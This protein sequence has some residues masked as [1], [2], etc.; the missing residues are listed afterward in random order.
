MTEC[1]LAGWRIPCGGNLD[2]HHVIPREWTR[3]NPAARRASEEPELIARVCSA[4]NAWTKLADVPEAR[5]LLLQHQARLFGEKAVR[6]AL[7]KIPRK[8][9]GNDLTWDRLMA[10]VS[11]ETKEAS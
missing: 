1:A 6:E 4:H 3:G 7:E 8:V 5:A 11:V 2:R 10:A 9:R